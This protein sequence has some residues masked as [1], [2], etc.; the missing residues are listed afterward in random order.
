MICRYGRELTGIRATRIAL[1]LR[2][3]NYSVACTMSC[4]GMVNFKISETAYNT[5]RFLEYL[6][7]I[8][9]IF[10]AREISEAYLVMDN[11]PFHKTAL[12]QN[13]IRAFN[14]ANSRSTD[15]LVLSIEASITNLTSNDCLGFYRHME[16][17]LPDCIQRCPVEKKYIL[18]L[19]F[20]CK[21]LIAQSGKL[22][23]QSCNY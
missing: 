2:S 22:A 8:C 21:K 13:T 18:I 10:R 12:V 20:L 3:R 19:N 15:E 23:D 4:E 5:E 7:D 6:L 1:A 14:H 17:C 9:E 16:S 11:V